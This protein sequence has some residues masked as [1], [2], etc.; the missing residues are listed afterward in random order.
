M[1]G[2]FLAVMTV[3][4]LL[5]SCAGKEEDN[6]AEIAGNAARQYYS[7]LL[8]GNCDAFVDGTC[9]KGSIRK[10]Y[11]E[12]LIENARMFIAQQKEDHNGMKAVEVKRVDIDSLH[13][14]AN[15]FLILTYGDKTS[16]QVLLPMVKSNGLWYMK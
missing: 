13:T 4:C 6:Q 9:R 12:Q 2:R 14:S 16:E 1:T 11:R 3:V 10:E 7:Y 15:V 5:F 8:A